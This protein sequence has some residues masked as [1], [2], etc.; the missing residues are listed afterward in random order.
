MSTAQEPPQCY[1]MLRQESGTLTDATVV[2]MQPHMGPQAAAPRPTP[3]QQ[4]P[5]TTPCTTPPPLHPSTPPHLHPSTLH[6]PRTLCAQDGGT[7][8]NVTTSFQVA[9][10]PY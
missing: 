8:V 6:T 3:T 5:T 7:V 10:P 2:A 9:P 1:A 4:H